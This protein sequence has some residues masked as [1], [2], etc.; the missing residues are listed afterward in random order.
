MSA[1]AVATTGTYLIAITGTGGSLSHTASVTLVVST[2]PPSAIINGG[3]ETGDFTGWTA[4]GATAVSTRSHSGSYSAQ[5]GS[6]SPYVYDD[7]A[8]S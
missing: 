4:S 1:T 3:F 6:A 2:P 8:V 5:V 7:V